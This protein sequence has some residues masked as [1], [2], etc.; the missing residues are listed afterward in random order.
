[1]NFLVLQYAGVVENYLCTLFSY[2][3]EIRDFIRLSDFNRD[4]KQLMR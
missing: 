1:M 2:L 4:K 3:L